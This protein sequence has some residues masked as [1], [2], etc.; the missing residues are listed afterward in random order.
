MNNKLKLRAPDRNFQHASQGF[1]LIEILIVATI[2]ALILG[3][4][5]TRIFGAGDDAK[6]RLTKSQLSGISGYL[7]LYKLD[8]G[9]YPTTQ[10]GLNA[11]LQAP[12]GV[13]NWNGPY[14]KG[15]APAIKDTFGNDLLYRAPGE[16][17]RPYDLISLGADGREGGE[18]ANKD[19]KHGE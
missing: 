14:A 9:K 7:D 5:A 11:L 10:E 17:S 18:G 2:I 13:T 19:I 8:V 16:Q 6:A 3:Y 4:A 15:G 12:A 1:T